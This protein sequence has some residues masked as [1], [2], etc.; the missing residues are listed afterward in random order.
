LLVEKLHY[1]ACLVRSR[2]YFVHKLLRLVNL[3]LTG[4]ERRGDGDTWAR[5]RKAAN[6]E[7]Q[8]DSTPEFMADVGWWGWFVNQSI[9]KAG[10][11]ITD[12][13]F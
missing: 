1:A 6:A 3:H 7:R 13:F 8:L 4:E 5:L 9:R 2:W 10:E 11:R 12:S